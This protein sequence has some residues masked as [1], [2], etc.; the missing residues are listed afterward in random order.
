LTGLASKLHIEAIPMKLK[1]KEKFYLQSVLK[2]IVVFKK[3]EIVHAV[4]MLLLPHTGSIT[5]Y[6]K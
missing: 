1:A 4:T 2:K 6:R 3:K 5:I